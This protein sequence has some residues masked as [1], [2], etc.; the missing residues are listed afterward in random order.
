MEN[1]VSLELYKMFFIFMPFTEDFVLTTAAVAW[2]LWESLD[3]AL[4]V[5]GRLAPI[6]R[7]ALLAG[8]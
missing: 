3:R 7:T 8:G 4:S 6:H 2:V 1:L 5:A